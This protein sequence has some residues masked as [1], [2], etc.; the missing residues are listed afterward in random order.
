MISVYGST[1][2]IGKKYCELTKNCYKIPKDQNEPIENCSNIIYF[3]STT[4]NYN[5]FS[6]ITLD[7]NTNLFK[8]VKVLEKWKEINPTATFNFISSWFVY[9]NKQKFPVLENEVCNPSGFYSITKHCAENLLISYC[10]TFDLKYRILRLGN[11]IGPNDLN[12]SKKKNAITSMISDLKNN[13]PIFLYDNAEPFRDIIYVDDCVNA[14]N[15]CLN[16][17][18]INDTINISNSEP[19]SLN[20][21]FKYVCEKYNFDKNLIS[22]KEAPDFHK[23]VQ[24]KNMW[25][26]NDKL[27]STGYYAKY[28]I[29]SAIDKIVESI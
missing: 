5:V 28:D 11:V 7:I 14:I 18:L 27:K 24:S 21:I 8:L 26:N 12:S 29:F 16:S 19:I 17:N 3:I 23:M 2:F 20:E 1:G 13:K 10:K 25:L 9:G 4:D 15:C 6:D 22:Y